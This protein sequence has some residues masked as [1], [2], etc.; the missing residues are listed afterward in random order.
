MY[1]ARRILALL[2]ALALCLPLAPC[3]HAE[4]EP[5]G[6]QKSME[7]PAPE[8]EITPEPEPEFTPEPEPEPT[9]EPAP[10]DTP[11]PEPADTPE[12]E[13]TPEPTPEPVDESEE[14]ILTHPDY[15][16]AWNEAVIYAFLTGTVGFNAA[17]ACGV[18]GTMYGESGFDP[19]TLGDHDTSFGICQW[20]DWG[21]GEGRWTNLKDFCSYY[22]YDWRTLEGQLYFMHYELATDYAWIYSEMMTF[23]NTA[24]GAYDAGYYW[25]WY[26]GVPDD[27]EYVS[28]ERGTYARDIFWPKYA[29]PCVV[30]FD[31]AGGH[32]VKD[33]SVAYGDEL[34]ELPAAVRPGYTF[35]GW[36]AEEN[37]AGER[38]AAGTVITE[39]AVWHALWEAETYT[40]AFDTRGGMEDPADMSVTFDD[41][42][43]ALPIPERRGYRFD[44]WFTAPTGGRRIMCDTPAAIPSDHTLYAHW[45]SYQAYIRAYRGADA[46]LPQE[47]VGEGLAVLGEVPCLAPEIFLGPDAGTAAGGSALPDAN[48]ALAEDGAPYEAAR[49]LTEQVGQ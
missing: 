32:E 37:G 25:C 5:D 2:L 8:T 23:P 28:T 21:D 14:L 31:A 19:Y 47:I 30:S 49:I 18:L 6:A 36:Y 48:A 44:G 17:A 11:E 38:L 7:E 4:E 16:E 27:A 33:I 1:T 24:Q 39:D 3:A 41:A 9:P 22:G 20:H 34:T 35:L 12:P 13:I 40:V 45:T 43:G 29:P 26:F 10:D 46:A 42:Y 15:N